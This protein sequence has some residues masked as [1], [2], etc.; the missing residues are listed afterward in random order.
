M[1]GAPVPPTASWCATRGVRWQAVHLL[2]C[3]WGLLLTLD[4]PKN[5]KQLRPIP[6]EVPTAP[7]GRTH[8]CAVQRLRHLFGLQRRY[9]EPEQQAVFC[10]Y[11]AVNPPRE[12][13]TAAGFAN[14][15]ER[16]ATAAL[17]LFAPAGLLVRN[18]VKLDPGL[19]FVTPKS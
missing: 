14:R 6:V 15:F 16:L 5:A 10:S 11:A 1:L 8:L 9:C 4:E 12:A 2:T 3:R 18:E 17:P 19:A 7:V 13:L